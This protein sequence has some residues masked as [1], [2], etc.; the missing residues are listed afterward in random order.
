M[1]DVNDLKNVPEE[2]ES[3]IMR[4]KREADEEAKARA[5]ED[6]TRPARDQLSSIAKDI[7]GENQLADFM[8]NAVPPMDMPRLEMPRV[9]S[10]IEHAPL[11]VDGEDVVV[12][13]LI[14]A[15]LREI[16]ALLQQ[17]P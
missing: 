2:E 14:L 4:A 7:L 13:R 15:E 11:A 16:K 12:L 3:A 17:R 10:Y 1:P 9:S 8:K 6:M 5:F